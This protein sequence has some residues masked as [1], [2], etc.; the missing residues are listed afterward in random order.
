[1]CPVKCLYRQ[2][3]EGLEYLH[4]SDIIHRYGIFGN[5]LCPPLNM[6]RDV[7]MQNILLTAKGF[8]KL[9]KLNIGLS[10]L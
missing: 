10:G 4:K 1:M 6:S 2:L 8:L 7:K 9:G 3:L 5:S